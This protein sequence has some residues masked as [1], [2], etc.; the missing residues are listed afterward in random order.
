MIQLVGLYLA[1]GA[2][3]ANGVDGVPVRGAVRWETINPS[4]E[5]SSPSSQLDASA[6]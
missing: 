3:Y 4:T 5:D 2:A 6:R 1:G